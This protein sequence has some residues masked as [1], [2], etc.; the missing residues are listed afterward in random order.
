[1]QLENAKTLILDVAELNV[2]VG[3]SLKLISPAL[4]RVNLSAH[5]AHSAQGA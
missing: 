3:N 4:V 1:M 5:G 2:M